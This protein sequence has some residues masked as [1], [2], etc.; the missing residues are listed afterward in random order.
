MAGPEFGDLSEAELEMLGDYLNQTQ[1]VYMQSVAKTLTTQKFGADHPFGSG[2]SDVLYYISEVVTGTDRQVLRLHDMK[3]SLERAVHNR[4]L[5]VDLPEEAVITPEKLHQWSIRSELTSYFSQVGT[6]I[7][8]FSTELV[9]NQ[10][11]DNERESNRVRRDVARKSQWEREWLLFVTG[12]IDSGEKDQIRTAYQTRNDF[13]HSSPSSEAIGSVEELESD[14][15]QAWDSVNVLHTKLH[16]LEM[17]Y[18][19]TENVLGNKF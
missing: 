2:L 3:Q 13:V 19:I 14:I 15:R 9:M 7:E 10:V 8:E 1:D 4:P 16:G 12:V 5:D 11:V 17:E 18:R 6:L